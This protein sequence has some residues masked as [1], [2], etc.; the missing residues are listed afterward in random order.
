M[1]RYL[2]HCSFKLLNFYRVNISVLRWSLFEIG[3]LLKGIGTN[4]CDIS[5][6]MPLIAFVIFPFECLFFCEVHLFRSVLI[7]RNMT[8]ANTNAPYPLCVILAL[9]ME[10]KNKR[11]TDCLLCPV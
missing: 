9:E 3:N 1:H 6:L 11:I 7:M 2:A 5:D 10:K 8:Y 4:L